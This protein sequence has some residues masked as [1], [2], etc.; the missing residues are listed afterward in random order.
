VKIKTKK[1]EVTIKRKREPRRQNRFARAITNVL[2]CGCLW[3]RDE[4]E[5]KD[6]IIET[7]QKVTSVTTTYKILEP[8]SEVDRLQLKETRSPA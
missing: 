2:L 1:E 3:R 4:E 7:T 6:E 5:S 8:K